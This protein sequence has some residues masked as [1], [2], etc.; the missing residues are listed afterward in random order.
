MRRIG[1]FMQFAAGG[2]TLRAKG[3][4][5]FGLGQPKRSP[6]IDNSLQPAG[7]TEEGQ[8][9]FIEGTILDDGTVDLTALVGLNNTPVTLELATGKVLQGT[10]GYYSHEGTGSTE[11]G[12]FP[13]RFD[14]Q[15]LEEVA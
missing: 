12:E 6:V 4:F 7:F 15:S 9:P 10:G 3:N 11:N 5:T 13:V 8:S 1:G 14:F 2:R